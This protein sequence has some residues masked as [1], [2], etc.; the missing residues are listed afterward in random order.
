MPAR[1]RSAL[2]YDRPVE[3]S[4]SEH[5]ALWHAV[6][7]S[8]TRALL[9]GR[10][11]LILLGAP[12]STFDYDFWLHIDDA[13]AFN[14]A[15][16][17]LGLWP[18]RTPEQARAVGRYVLENDLRVDVLVARAVP[19][20]EGQRIHFD[21]VWARHR[22]LEPTP[23]AR[24]AVPSITDLISTKRFGARAKDAEDIAFLELLKGRST[25]GQE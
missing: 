10:Q 18:S 12:V 25:G 24:V 22:I 15:L 7:R 1:A 20:Q 2:C 5:E 23:G 3:H 8:R 4:D 16:H 13:A 19:T 17:P 6:A 9:I 14:A 21:D 11:A